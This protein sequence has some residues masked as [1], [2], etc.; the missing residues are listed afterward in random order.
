[1]RWPGRTAKTQVACTNAERAAA[2]SPLMCCFP[3]TAFVDQVSVRLKCFHGV[4]VALGL[5]HISAE[6]LIIVKLYFL[7]N[8]A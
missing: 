4:V 5:R 6:V 1:M 3:Y 8:F 2:A 7:L